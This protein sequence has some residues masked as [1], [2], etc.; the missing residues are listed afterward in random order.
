MSH[1]QVTC[2]IT[3][4]DLSA[5]FD[6]I[7]HTILLECFS[8]WFGIS[9]MYPTGCHPISCLLILL[10]FSSLVYH[11]NS[12]NSTIIPLIYLTMSYSH[13]LIWYT[14]NLGVIFDTNLSFAQHISSISK[15]CFH[16]SRDLRRRPIRNILIKLAYFLYHCYFSHSFWN[17]LLQ[18]SSTQSTY[19]TNESSSTCPLLC[20][21]C[22][23]QKS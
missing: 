19:Y 15:S 9:S 13:L 12:L 17:W 18:L 16:N 14:R 20:R 4:L 22:C 2:L 10:S 6:T 23:H 3:L 1:Q 7:D 8:F 11:N 5:A 21:S